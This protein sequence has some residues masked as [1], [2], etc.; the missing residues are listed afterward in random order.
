MLR[1]LILLCVSLGLSEPILAQDLLLPRSTGNEAY[2]ESF[3]L[4]ADLDD[5]SY[6]LLQ[7]LF[8]NAG[9]G[10]EKAG[11]RGLIVPPTGKGFNEGAQFDRDEWSYDGKAKALKVGDCVLQERPESL[12]FKVQ[13]KTYKA[14]L[15]LHRAAQPSPL[16]RYPKK[17]G[18]D[19]FHVDI[20]VPWAKVT[21]SV[22]SPVYTKAVKGYGYIDHS[23]SNCLVP[24]IA[25]RWI[26]FR[27]LD[28]KNPYLFQF[29][30][31]PDQQ[32][33]TGWHWEAHANRPTALQSPKLQGGTRSQPTEL[34]FHNGKTTVRLKTSKLL[35][36][37]R[38]VADYGLLGRLAKPWIGDP[39]TTTYHAT[40][41]LEDGT[42]ISGL[43]E[44][45]QIAE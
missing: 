14:D 44:T 15:T 4:L 34:Q 37:Y 33:I 12:T 7:Y 41:T 45:A 24:N 28:P 25:N 29:H 27:G 39:T 6:V 11:C 3:T 42:V 20:L 30:F 13:T 1:S 19:F 26:R 2:S 18:N 22:A 43:F 23:R 40:V 8:T 9:L 10:D 31:P 38:P 35:H 17:K 16:P 21:G 32:T 5:G 36:R